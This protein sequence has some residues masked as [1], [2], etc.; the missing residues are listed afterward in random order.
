MLRES[1]MDDFD[2]ESSWKKWESNRMPKLMRMS[3]AKKG[4]PWG[5]DMSL[6]P[7]YT[8]FE[9]SMHVCVCACVYSSVT[10]VIV[11][12]MIYSLGSSLFCS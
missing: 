1:E 11:H 4:G 3:L 8:T 5:C 7:S 9:V 12:Y 2:N 6:F 10:C